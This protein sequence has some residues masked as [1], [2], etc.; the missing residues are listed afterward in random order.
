MWDEQFER[1]LNTRSRG[2]NACLT[3]VT[4]VMHTA[5]HF[6]FRKSMLAWACTDQIK[7]RN[8]GNVL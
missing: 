1:N 5:L 2:S 4:V 6:K 8:H 7:N 3:A